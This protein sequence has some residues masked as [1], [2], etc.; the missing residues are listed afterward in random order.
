MA[1]QPL[2][3]R[4]DNDFLFGRR[5]NDLTPTLPVFI[6]SRQQAYRAAVWIKLMVTRCL[7]R[8]SPPAMT[9][10]RRRSR[11]HELN[12]RVLWRWRRQPVP[13]LSWCVAV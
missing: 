1:A 3:V 13:R 4:T 11:T 7:M 10:L 5:I 8:T 12:H 2:P 6:T 9:R